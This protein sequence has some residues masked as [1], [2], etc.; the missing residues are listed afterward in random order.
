MTIEDKLEKTTMTEAQKSRGAYFITTKGEAGTLPGRKDHVDIMH[1]LVEDSEFED[2]SDISV[3]LSLNEFLEETQM[4]RIRFVSNTAN[5]TIRTIPNQDQI[6]SLEDLVNIVSDV[7][8][9]F[10]FE[11]I[12]HTNETKSFENFLVYIKQIEKDDG[13]GEK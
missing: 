1:G 9:D 2:Q 10:R 4:I 11:K 13:N 12:Q 7:E 5:M 8:F 6:K 3:T